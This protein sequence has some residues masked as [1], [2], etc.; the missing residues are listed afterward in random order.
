MLLDTVPVLWLPLVA[1]LPL[2]PPEAV[3]LVALL[4]LQVRVAA[5]PLATTFEEAVSEA[6]GLGSLAARLELA[7]GSTVP[8]HAASARPISA[9]PQRAR[10]VLLLLPTLSC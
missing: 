9:Q 2:Q 5:A 10:S 3:Q 7:S 1:S 8:E 4:E 6:D